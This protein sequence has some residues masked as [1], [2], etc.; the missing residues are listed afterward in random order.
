MSGLPGITYLGRYSM[1]DIIFGGIILA[2]VISAVIYIRR[3]KKK[4]IKCIGC[5][6]GVSCANKGK[7]PSESGTK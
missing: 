2:I 3:S 7:C 6:E 1:K 5:P 4:G